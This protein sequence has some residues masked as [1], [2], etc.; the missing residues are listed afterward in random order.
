MGFVLRVAIVALGLWLASEIVPGIRVE[1]RWTLLWAALVLDVVNAIVWPLIV[2]LTLPITI[3]TLSL[4]LLVVNAG[5]LGHV[6][7][8]FDDFSIAA[9]GRP[10]VAP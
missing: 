3:L 9:S 5:M 7:W 10:L 1:G 4:F 2:I 6:A 8:L